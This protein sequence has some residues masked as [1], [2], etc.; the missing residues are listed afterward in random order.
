MEIP[1]TIA[2]LLIMPGSPWDNVRP[3][4]LLKGTVMSLYFSSHSAW[5]EINRTVC[6]SMHVYL[7]EKRERLEKER[8]REIMDLHCYQVSIET[9]TMWKHETQQ[10]FQYPWKRRETKISK[11]IRWDPGNILQSTRTSSEGSCQC[12]HSRCQNATVKICTPS[13]KPHMHIF[14]SWGELGRMWSDLAQIPARSPGGPPVLL[15]T[16]RLPSSNSS[17]VRTRHGAT[18]SSR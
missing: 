17:H 5:W 2:G 7:R 1:L 10:E 16:C 18:H 12:K 14:L 6:L 9:V 8:E 15:S 4:P 3:W 11:T 13:L